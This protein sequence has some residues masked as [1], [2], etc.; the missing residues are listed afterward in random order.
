MF[1][2]TLFHILYENWRISI[3]LL[4][5]PLTFICFAIYLYFFSVI[6]HLIYDNVYA[7]YK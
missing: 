1:N 2:S 7:Q 6:Y 3:N 4:F 5:I